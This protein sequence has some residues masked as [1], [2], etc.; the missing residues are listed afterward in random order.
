MIFASSGNSI[1]KKLVEKL[2]M[3][4]GLESQ[5]ED[6]DSLTELKTALHRPRSF[7]TIV[8][9]AVADSM[10][11]SAILA[12]GPWLE[13]YRLIVILP[14]DEK[15][16]VSQAHNLRPRYL[17]FADS[18]LDDVAAVLAKMMKREGYALETAN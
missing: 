12:L 5:W 11:L 4:L 2:G 17:G 15:E 14:G 10:E 3:M 7:S 18:P 1:R 8:V 16:A 9:L 6:I 13:D